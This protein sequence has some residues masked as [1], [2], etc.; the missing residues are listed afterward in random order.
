MVSVG[1]LLGAGTVTLF[2]LYCGYRLTTALRLYAVLFGVT[3]TQSP[4]LTGD[5]AVAIEGTVTVDEEAPHSDLATD[6]Y[7]S[8]IAAYVWRILTT[9]PG[10]GVVASGVEFG[11]FSI[12]TDS[13]DVRVDPSWLRETHDAPA[14]T[15]VRTDGYVRSAPYRSSL[16]GSPYV[17]FVHEAS[18]MPLSRV[19]G[20][21][22]AELD[23]SVD[24][25][26]LESKA[27]PEGVPL[28]V[29]GELSTEGG[30]P[31]IRGTDDTPLFLANC[32]L[33]DVRSTLRGRAL[34]YGI[35]IAG[36]LGLGFAI[37]PVSG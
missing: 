32:D 16:W 35:L 8:P 4:A 14:L 20:V 1:A 11:S 3:P 30:T 13:V 34:Y 15:D 10:G 17:H 5:D 7:G 26:T 2:C 31:T 37:L 23:I 21:I 18:S 19:S 9:G 29:Y 12:A 33:D 24:T 22:A 6:D 36:A 27:V 25:N 28:S